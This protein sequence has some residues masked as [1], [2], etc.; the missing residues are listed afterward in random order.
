MT[1]KASHVRK[2]GT[3]VEFRSKRSVA[4]SHFD[5]N[6]QSVGEVNRSFLEPEVRCGL[7]VM[8]TAIDSRN[9]LN[10]PT[11]I[12]GTTIRATGGLGRVSGN[13]SILELGFNQLTQGRLCRPNDFVWTRHVAHRKHPMTANEV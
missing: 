12:Q 7:N 4:G 8:Q 11:K 3:R 9:D 13:E 2:N 6:E 5:T 1:A 10:A